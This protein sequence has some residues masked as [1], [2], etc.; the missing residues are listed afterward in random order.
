MS[1]EIR[2][3]KRSELDSNK[4]MDLVHQSDASVYNQIH[5]LDSLAE[6]WV[7]LVLG[8][9]QGGMAIPYTIRLG[10]KGIYTPNFLRAVDWM[11]ERPA[12]FSKVE[13]LL[14]ANFTRAHLKV[15]Q[16]IFDTQAEFFFQQINQWED[17]KLG[18]QSKRSIKKFDKTGLQIES[19][20]L[21]EAL[22][23][24]VDEL[25]AKVKGLRT[26]DFLRFQ[27]LLLNYDPDKCFCFGIRGNGLH[28]ATIL[29][30]WKD[31]WLYIKGGVDAYGKQHG[32][33][34]ALMYDSIQRAFDKGKR[35]SFEGSTVDSIRQFNLCFGAKDQTYFS[36]NWNHSP[37]W[38][39]I[40]LTLR[41]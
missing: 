41:K 14:K 19:I 25:K 26:I 21:D 36:W 40:L 15:N 33:M 35:F 7:A 24:V 32:C 4:W 13:T 18:S 22:P 1:N 30:E 12:D 29:I 31:Q 5:Y 11:G 38:F 37:W 9:Y 27:N 20:R 2:I 6:H 28:A 16:A 3:V 8:D 10:V 34:H 17:V 23:L 39:R